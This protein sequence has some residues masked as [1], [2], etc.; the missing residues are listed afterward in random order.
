MWVT[1]D[2]VTQWTLCKL[3]QDDRMKTLKP[4]LLSTEVSAESTSEENLRKFPEDE[5][6]TPR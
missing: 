1:S 5:H 2:V 6:K 4:G 3:I